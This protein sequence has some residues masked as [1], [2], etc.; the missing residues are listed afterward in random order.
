MW[1]WLD[2]IEF[3]EPAPPQIYIYQ[4]LIAKQF[5]EVCIAGYMHALANRGTLFV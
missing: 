1:G 3:L 4:S 5:V 2:L